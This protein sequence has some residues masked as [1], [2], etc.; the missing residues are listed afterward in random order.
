MFWKK[1]AILHVFCNDIFKTSGINPYIDFKGQN[2]KMNFECY[3]QFGASLTIRLGDYK[4][5][6]HQDVDTSRYRK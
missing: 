5:K 1:Q 4:E 6:T 3:R 2:M